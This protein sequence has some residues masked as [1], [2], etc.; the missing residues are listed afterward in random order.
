MSTRFFSSSF[1]SL[2]VVSVISLASI[3]LA[4]APVNAQASAEAILDEYDVTAPTLGYGDTGEAVADV[5]NFLQNQG[6]YQSEVDGVYGSRTGTA[7][8]EFQED[9]GL[10]ADGIVGRQ[11]WNA[12]LNFE[13]ETEDTFIEEESDFESETDLDLGVE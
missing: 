3:G 8:R 7:V 1:V 13:A 11:T 2:G 9:Q 6:Y 12:M 5:Q 10:F 4:G